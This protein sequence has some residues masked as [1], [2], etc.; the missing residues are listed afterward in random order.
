[1]LAGAGAARL[2]RRVDT[3]SALDIVARC[4]EAAARDGTEASVGWTRAEA[5]AGRRREMTKRNVDLAT[6]AVC[7]PWATFTTIDLRL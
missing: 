6:G 1:V 4:D 2:E 7:R 5:S 3:D